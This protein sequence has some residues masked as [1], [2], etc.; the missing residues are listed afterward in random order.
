MM[1]MWKKGRKTDSDFTEGETSIR[2]HSAEIGLVSL[3][4][5]GKVCEHAGRQA[6]A[7]DTN[8]HYLSPCMQCNL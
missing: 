4:S 1:A 5:L 7:I 3:S 8:L 6:M 2:S